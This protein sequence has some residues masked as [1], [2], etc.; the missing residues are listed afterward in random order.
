[1]DLL[2]IEN[3]RFTYPSRSTPALDGVTLNIKKG[4]FITVCGASGCGKSTLLSHI[5]PSLTPHGYTS[6]TITLDGR[7]IKDLTQREEAARIGFVMQ[8][9]EDQLVTDKVWHELAFG[10]ERLGLSSADI[11]ARVAETAEYFGIA[12]KFDSNVSVLSGGEKQLVNLASVMAMRPE[13]L[14]LDEP[15][16][17]L[18]P[19]A[20]SEYLASVS[21]LNRELGITVILA[22]H[23]LEDAF[24]ISDRVIV[25]DRGRIVADSSPRKLGAAMPR[26]LYDYMPTAACVHAALQG[27]G[28]TPI[29]VRD[30]REFIS[31]YIKTHT[32][33]P[34]EA[35]PDNYGEVLLS[36]RELYYRYEPN[37]RDVIS[38]FSLEA[39]AGE[40]LC[41]LGGNGSGKSTALSLLAGIYEPQSGEI[42]RHGKCAFL[43]QDPTTLFTSSTVREELCEISQDFYKIAELCEIE[44]LLDFHPFDLSG[45]ERQRT[46]LAK[47]LLCDPDII[48]VDEPTKGMDPTFKRTLGKIFRT[49][50]DDDKAIIM[51]SHDAEFCAEIAD[52]CVLFFDGAIVSESPPREFFGAMEYYTT[53]ASRMTRGFLSAVTADE[54]ILQLGGELP[55]PRTIPKEKKSPATLQE[56]TPSP[57][58]KKRITPFSVIAAVLMLLLIPL[59][60]WAGSRFFGDR[61]YYIT[62]LLVVLETLT[63]F[64]LMFEGKRPR[65]REIAVIASLCAI[66]VAGRAVFFMVPECKPVVAITIIAGAALGGGRGF[67]VGALTMLASNLIFG[68]GPWTPWQML[69]MGLVGLLAGCVFTFVK[70]S[71]IKLC[72]FGIFAAIIIYGGIM[73]LASMLLWT[74]SPTLELVITYLIS[75]FPID[76]V[77]A[78]ATA[79]FLAVVGM[80]M[81][82]KLA[83]VR[84][85]YGI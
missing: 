2:K 78:A 35:S 71:R 1:M 52:R 40:L 13:I 62:S 59:T 69:A 9:P 4:E 32:P 46:A 25:M 37:L 45:G 19:I 75:G 48:L 42:L 83:R 70:P 5:K 51:V 38:A 74:D 7:S 54:V 72:I 56:N 76:L 43:P 39:R 26:E 34:S 65:A 80:P 79:V 23:R 16:S 14:I 53:S 64:L 68:Q 44:E 36:A 21:R 50:L 28:D 81:A 77:R 17:Q 12:D 60:V 84:I 24:A 66:G 82:E 58:Q 6:G 20:A 8:S 85:K 57:L 73:N 41:I 3:L 67:T 33:I 11:R 55:K 31:E 18:D 30:G 27:D 47:I 10:L 29:T 15:T 63:V 61:R 49:L 22:E